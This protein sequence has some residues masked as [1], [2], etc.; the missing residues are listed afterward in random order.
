M[1]TP[2]PF[3]G[4]SL[5]PSRS[6]GGG[7]AGDHEEEGSS[8]PRAWRLSQFGLRPVNDQGHVLPSKLGHCSLGWEI[9]AAGPA[10]SGP[11][12]RAPA[13]SRFGGV[14]L[15]VGRRP[16]VLLDPRP[17]R[18]RSKSGHA[19]VAAA[20]SSALSRQPRPLEHR[21]GAR[22]AVRERRWTL[23]AVEGLSDEGPIDPPGEDI[24]QAG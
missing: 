20:V 13:P 6:P 1:L 11:I 4:G 18:T 21:G 10:G 19:G 24:C 3:W 22:K 17:V 15:R 9:D 12:G 2:F 5:R 7:R 23:P 16:P 14:P 8:L